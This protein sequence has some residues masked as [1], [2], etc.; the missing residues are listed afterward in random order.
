M[1]MM[2][3]IR[4]MMRM[5]MGRRRRKMRMRM[6]LTE[7]VA[8]TGDSE[9]ENCHHLDCVMGLPD[10]PDQDLDY[11]LIQIITDDGDKSPATPTN[12]LMPPCG[13]CLW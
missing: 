10:Q 3:R 8:E 11:F 4:M 9:T 13:Q 6:T 1:M 2:M 7:S 5:M 12:V